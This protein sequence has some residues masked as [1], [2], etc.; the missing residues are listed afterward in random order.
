MKSYEELMSIPVGVL[1]NY[2]NCRLGTKPD[3]TPGIRF[4]VYRKGGE[5]GLAVKVLSARREEVI[6]FLRERKER[7]AA[8][9][10]AKEAE[11][12]EMERLVDAIPGLREIQRAKAAARIDMDR[13]YDE[14]EQSEH[15]NFPCRNKPH[16]D[17]SA[18]YTQY[19]AA[20]AYLKALKVSCKYTSW[21][22]YGDEAM[23]RIARNP[24]NYAAIIAEM[25]SAVSKEAL[26]WAYNN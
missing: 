3:G 11:A 22:H 21:S 26:L 6:S 5:K 4:A 15:G 8:E 18:M 25:E 7:L 14:W 16:Y 23:N 13:W 12:A 2:Y 1:A 24:E 10:A 19:P 17:F 9:K 20:A